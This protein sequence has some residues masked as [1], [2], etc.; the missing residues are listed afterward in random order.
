MQ[1]YHYLSRVVREQ[2][3][4]MPQEALTLRSALAAVARDS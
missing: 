1:Y 3:S 4:A 2:G